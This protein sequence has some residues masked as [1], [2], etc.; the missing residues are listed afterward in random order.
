MLE[1]QCKH[2][3]YRYY[4]EV[5]RHEVE[6]QLVNQVCVVNWRDCLGDE[7]RQRTKH[8]GLSARDSSSGESIFVSLGASRETEGHA[9]IMFRSLDR[10]RVR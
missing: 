9:I 10:P 2:D 6:I 7:I 8:S 4:Y 1:A 3:D 5:I